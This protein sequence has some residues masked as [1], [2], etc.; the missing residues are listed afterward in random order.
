[1]AIAH[2]RREY[3]AGSLRRADLD[4]DPVAQF[5]RWF[6]AAL[7]TKT[8]GNFFRRIG[9][10]TYKWFQTVCGNV[11]SEA[12]AMTLATADKNGRP[13]ARMVLLKGVDARGFI[14]YTHHEGPKGRDLAENPQ[15]ALV[16]YWPELERQICVRGNVEKLPAAESDAYFQSRPRGSRL[17]AW[18][19]RQSE[20]VPDRKFMEDKLRQ[21][22]KQ[23]SSDVPRPEYWGGYVLAPTRIEFWQGRANRLHDRFCYSKQADSSW[24]IERLAP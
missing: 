8:S 3:A 19:W 21:L 4:A 1:M 24:T 15:A 2:L 20:V 5:N 12:N 14:F 13:S 11:S 10:A 6:A 16:F 9:I 18:V 22:Q 23:F 7:E 17:A